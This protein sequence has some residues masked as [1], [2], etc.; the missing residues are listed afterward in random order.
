MAVVR[1]TD[2]WNYD[3]NRISD[4]K[5][6]LGAFADAVAGVA[7]AP[8]YTLNNACPVDRRGTDALAQDSF[9]RQ[10][11]AGW[12]SSDFGGPY[13]VGSAPSNYSVG[14]GGGR[15]DVPAAGAGR[16]ARL[17]SVVGRD[18]NLRVMVA[19][20]KTA[21]GTLGQYLAI[22]GRRTASGGEYRFK[23]RLRPDGAVSLSVSKTDSAGKE[24]FIGNEALAPNL[25]HAPGAF[26]RNSQDLWIKFPA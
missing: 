3:E 22:V 24:T 14:S 10:V 2:R 16:T 1:G 17:A 18:I 4:P 6:A 20:D 15:I 5:P 9:A 21:T 13:T 26:M 8:E 11:T 25:S 19:T 7:V 12:G 23:T